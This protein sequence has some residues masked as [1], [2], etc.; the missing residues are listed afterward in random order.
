MIY[1]DI[2][3]E[4][5]KAYYR[6]RKVTEQRWEGQSL[7]PVRSLRGHR[8]GIVDCVI[9]EDCNCIDTRSKKKAQQTD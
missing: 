1:F 6:Q 9:E 7:F 3:K 8:A 2:L 4:K 5:K